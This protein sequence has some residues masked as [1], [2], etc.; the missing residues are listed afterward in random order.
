MLR[1]RFAAQSPPPPASSV[2]PHHQFAGQVEHILHYLLSQPKFL[3]LRSLVAPTGCS[4][5]VLCLWSR[6]F[7]SN[8]FQRRPRLASAAS[9]GPLSTLLSTP[10]ARSLTHSLWSWP[11]LSS[12]STKPPPANCA[13]YSCAS[14]SQTGH[15]PIETPPNPELR[16]RTVW[17][18]VVPRASKERGFVSHGLGEHLHSHD[19]VSGGSRLELLSVRHARV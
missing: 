16:I 10:L 4:C 2:I 8:G 15:S 3:N 12:V 6:V 17:G 13:V 11:L 9:L 18:C 19:G 5:C 7:G 14:V 1:A